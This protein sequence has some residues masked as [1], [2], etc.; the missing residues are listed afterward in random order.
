[1]KILQ[2]KSNLHINMIIFIIIILER[3][4]NLIQFSNKIVVYCGNH[5]SITNYESM[6]SN[7]KNISI[8]S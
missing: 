3:Q 8:K 6:E 2:K 5:S 7:W 1:M 4:E